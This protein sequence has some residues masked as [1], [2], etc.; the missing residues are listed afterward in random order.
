MKR[1]ILLYDNTSCHYDYYI[2]VYICGDLMLQTSVFYEIESIEGYNIE[3]NV[4]VTI[5]KFIN[6]PSNDNHFEI[7]FETNTKPTLNFIRTN[8]PELLV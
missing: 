2:L 1:Y 6:N 4:Y 8:Y 3:N 5:K 7:M